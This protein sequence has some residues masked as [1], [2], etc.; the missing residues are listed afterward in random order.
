MAAITRTIYTAGGAN[1]LWSNGIYK[2]GGATQGAMN[3][4]NSAIQDAS[5]VIQSLDYTRDTPK[6]TLTRFGS[7]GFTR[8]ANEAE[9]GEIEMELYPT[10]GIGH[11]IA[12]LCEQTL[13]ES[14]QRLNVR[15]SAGSI[16]DG[17]LTS[18]EFE[19]SVGDVPT[20]SLSF[21]GNPMDPS[22]TAKTSAAAAHAGQF[23]L[24]EP[25][26]GDAAITATIGAMA[27]VGSSFNVLASMRSDS[28]VSKVG[29]HAQ[30][31]HEIVFPQTVSFSWDG[32]VESVTRIGRAINNA[33]YF[34]NPPGE[35]S[36][37]CEGLQTPGAVQGLILY[38]DDGVTQTNLAGQF[39]TNMEINMI[40]GA[41]M[42]ADPVGGGN[43]FDD[44]IGQGEIS[45]YSV[46]TSVGE[47]F[48][49]YSTTT[50][51]TAQGVKFYPT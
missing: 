27:N 36:F 23:T 51:G 46:S 14:P 2:N 26:G 22:G 29:N 5:L 8:V 31:M 7:K 9:T 44:G 3:A 48:S 6:E 18:V 39:G 13:A 12:N 35:A 47:L 34:G 19:A 41:T 16:S 45:S 10:V 11:A 24:G 28:M 38:G 4:N 25:A 43:N 42:G 37:E 17:L 40:I 30:A 32:G 15:T 1:I 20:L 49:T 50:E 21:M 33:T